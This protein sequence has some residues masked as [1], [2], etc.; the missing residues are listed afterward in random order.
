MSPGEPNVPLDDSMAD[1]VVQVCSYLNNIITNDSELLY[2]IELTKNGLMDSGPTALSY[3]ERL[4]S[5]IDRRRAWKNLHWKNI[6]TVDVHGPC[7]AYELVGGVFAK[8]SGRDM[9]FSWL[10]NA[11][12]PGHTVHIRDV[13][14]QLRDFAIDPTQDLVVLLEDNSMFVFLPAFA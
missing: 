13:G 14:M 9:F 1:L 7:T 12:S 8:T 4:H 6:A 2:F 5:L 11:R 3:A 10:P